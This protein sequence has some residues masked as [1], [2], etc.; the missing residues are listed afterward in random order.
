MVEEAKNEEEKNQ[1]INF[2]DIDELCPPERTIKINGK[3]Y[4][5]RGDISTEETIILA[6]ASKENINSPE[7]M[8]AL[9]DRV[10]TF[11]I[12]PIDKKELLKLSINTQLPKLISFLYGGKGKG[13]TSTSEKKKA[14]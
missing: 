2:L 11:F 10:I 4:K 3:N 1:G 14:E 5:V 8:E 12:T 13:E 6:R 9:I 7:T